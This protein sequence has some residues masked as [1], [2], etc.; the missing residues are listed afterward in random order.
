M[1]SLQFIE[2]LGSSHYSFAEGASS[3]EQLILGAA[4][5]GYSGIGLADRQ[6]LYGVVQ[7]LQATQEL[8]QAN[9]FF[10][11]GI[12]L[13]FDTCDPLFIYPL[14]KGAY[15]KL[16]SFL[17]NWA[18]EGMQLSGKTREKGLTPLP[19]KNFRNFLGGFK[20][21]AQDFAIFYV[22]GRYY[23]WVH[24]DPNPTRIHTGDKTPPTPS[25]AR[26]PTA[27]G[28][29]PFSL[30]EL[31]EICGKSHNSALSLVWPLLRSPG[32]ADYKKWLYE[33]SKNLDLPLVASSLPLFARAE[34]Q[35]LSD[36]LSSIRHTTPLK[37]LGYLRQAN[38]ERRLLFPQELEFFQKHECVDL[39][40]CPFQRSVEIKERQNF[41]LLELHYK[42]P[43]ESVPATHNPSSWLRDLCYKGARQRYPEGIPE[44]VEKQI[45]HE[46]ELI[47]D[48]QHEDYFLTLYDV[49]QYAREQKI[50]FQ[51]RGSAANSVICYCLGITAIDPVRMNLLFERF[52]SR[53]RG[54]PPDIDVDFEHERR[55]EVM[56]EV[57]RRYGRHRAAMVATV[58]C[59]RDRMAFRETAKAFDLKTPQITRLIS[60]MGR[61]RLKNLANTHEQT[62]LLKILEELKVSPQKWQKILELT[63]KLKHTPRHMGLHTG[64]FVLSAHNLS[65]ECIIE[66]ARMDNRSVIPWDKDDI[67]FLKWMKVDLLSLGMLTAIRK[68]FDLIGSRNALKE[69]LSLAKIPAECPEVFKALHKADTVGVFQIESRAQMN[70]LPRLVPKNFYDIVIEVAIV[71]PG[72]LQGGMVHPYL[73]R[74]QGLEPVVY[75]HP[76]LE[77]IL[78]KTLGVP[79][80]QEQVMKMAV[81]VGGFS[82]GEADQLRKVMSG[83]W[84]NK[85]KMNVLQEK[86]MNGMRSSGLSEDLV[87][88]IYKQIDGFG[89]YGFPESHS[90][91]FSILSYVSAWLKVHHPAEFVTALLNSQPMGFY[92][93]HSLIADAQRHGIKFLA[94]DISMSG[95]EHRLEFDSSHKTPCVRLGFCLISSFKK[96]EAQKIEELQNRGQLSKDL[97]P[98]PGADELLSWGLMSSTLRLLIE[99]GAYK[100]SYAK[101]DSRRK[102]LWNFLNLKHQDPLQKKLLFK[103][104]SV[105][106]PTPS[107]WDSLVADFESS[108]VSLR[109]HPAEIIRK[110]LDIE[111]KWLRS[112]DIYRLPDKSSCQIMGLL[113]VKQRP[114]TA[115]G[116]AFLTLEDEEGFFNLTL[117]AEV[118][119]KYRLLIQGQ[120]IL[121]AQGRVRSST[122]TGADSRHKAVSIEV[123][124]LWNPLL[125]LEDFKVR[126][127]G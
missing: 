83:A 85:S 4:E 7:A 9:F 67:D 39:P 120:S 55:E 24:Q 82:A 12:R 50:L 5:R 112:S 73:R 37:D 47:H 20:N 68:T 121:C 66:P 102:E 31:R 32:T 72:P 17:S 41:S 45:E 113:C 21:I 27:P 124:Q 127:W 22:S 100:T 91:S 75:D 123:A 108:A 96:Q 34:D 77:P 36:L 16:C 118:Y 80:F 101:E 29:A 61:E 103:E 43:K 19:W 33:I 69:K 62:E 79:I 78:S 42:Y 60:F 30:L 44:N 56:Q 8:P 86:L 10:A 90:A 53:E 115:G 38:S 99:T 107:L 87:A 97:Y 94:H 2:W 14:H 26:P 125:R 81:A 15:S 59:F 116:L 88:R 106:M 58:I 76:A 18:L 51:G 1:P 65:E 46:L 35:D 119:E 3:P 63:L 122:L 23:P 92:S 6:G 93:A 126:D 28:Q 71:R 89:E 25:F 11:P 64:G 95:W 98:L 13:H 105:D 117:F 48:L 70:M 84:R 57:Y 110:T 74:R 104:K 49:L 54:E 40:H 111:K 109:A 52:I 114:P